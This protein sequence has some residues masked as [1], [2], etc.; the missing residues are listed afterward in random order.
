MS[1]ETI[2]LYDNNFV[3]GGNKFYLLCH[4]ENAEFKQR[5]LS[6]LDMKVT[7]DISKGRLEG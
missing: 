5:Y 4:E 1:Q 7:T 6:W 2:G 3:F